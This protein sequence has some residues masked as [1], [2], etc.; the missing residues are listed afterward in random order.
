MLDSLSI[1]AT[2]FVSPPPALLG[3]SDLIRCLGQEELSLHQQKLT[4]LYR[5]N[6]E[7]IV[8]FAGNNELLLKESP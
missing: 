7:L 6:Q 1:I 4:A 2:L 3:I 5:L 8:L